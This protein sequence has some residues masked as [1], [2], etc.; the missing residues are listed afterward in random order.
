[1]KRM[2][3]CICLSLLPFFLTTN[4]QEIVVENPALRQEL[5][6]RFALDQNIRNEIIQKGFLHPDEDIVERMGLIDTENTARLKEI[7]SEYDWP[8]PS[9]IGQDGMNAMFNL[10]I[11]GDLALQEEVLALTAKSDE[12]PSQAHA[13]LL[14]SVLVAKG[15]HQ[16]YG[17]KIKPANEWQSGQP[18]PYPI[19]DESSVDKRRAE[20]GLPKLSEYLKLIQTLYFPNEN[21]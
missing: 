21:N 15:E 9:M 18:I 4:A 16:L 11:H 14:D 5:L 3:L 2:V 1:M 12:F 19:Q 20:A 17:T 8:N 10:V 13:L 6:E 7:V